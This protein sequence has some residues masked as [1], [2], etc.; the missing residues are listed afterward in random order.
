MF[1]SLSQIKS[2][3]IYDRLA[4]VIDAQLASI[5]CTRRTR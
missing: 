5:N 3:D 2:R 4:D 1:G